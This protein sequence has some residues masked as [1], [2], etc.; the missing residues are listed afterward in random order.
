MIM[1]LALFLK[2]TS[3]ESMQNKSLSLMCCLCASLLLL[4][5]DVTAQQN[6]SDELD[7]STTI[8][9][10]RESP[11]VLYIIPWAPP[12]G[13]GD[14]DPFSPN[15]GNMARRIFAPIERLEQQRL[16]RYYNATSVKQPN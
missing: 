5:I 11:K 7:L 6:S 16:I 8:E 9:G 1:S 14:I 3:I 12:Q 13:P 10:N 4:S 15:D 2:K